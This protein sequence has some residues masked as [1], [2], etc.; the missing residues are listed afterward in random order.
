MT[1][2]NKLTDV[3][4]VALFQGLGDGAA[5]SSTMNDNGTDGDVTEGDG[6]YSDDHLGANNPRQSGCTRCG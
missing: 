6:V 1:T 4:Y 5:S 2:T 3:D